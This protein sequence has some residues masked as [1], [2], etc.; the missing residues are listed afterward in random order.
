MENGVLREST[1]FLEKVSVER[2]QAAPCLQ[3]PGQRRKNF[4]LKEDFSSLPW[5]LPG[6]MIS[7]ILM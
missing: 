6:E 7:R 1:Y 3:T 4:P 5:L 2:C